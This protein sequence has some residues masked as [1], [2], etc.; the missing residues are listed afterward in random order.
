MERID[1]L[2]V[3]SDEARVSGARLGERLLIGVDD[4]PVATGWELKPE[5]LCRGD[6]CVP[7]HDP[8]G[9]VDGDLVDLAQVAARIGAV[10]AVDA[11]EGIAVF[12]GPATAVADVTAGSRQAPELALPTLDGGE[13]RLSDFAGQKRMVVAWS[14]WCGCRHELGAWQALQ[15]ELGEQNIRILSVALDEDVDAVRP[16]VDEA[17]ATFPVMV[18]REGMLAERYGVVNVP[19]T[20]WIDEDDQIVRPPDIAPGDDRWKDFTQ[21][22]AEAHHDA[23]RRWVND[24]EAPMTDDQV[25]AA[26]TWTGAVRAVV[27]PRPSWPAEL[28]PQH[29]TPPFTMAHVCEPPAARAVATPAMPL[30][31][32]QCDESVVELLPSWPSLFLPQHATPPPT[33]TAQ[34]WL[35][36]AARAMWASPRPLTATGVSRCVVE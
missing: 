15:E 18:D 36:P 23:L 33:V 10:I 28:S 21:K 8:A 30:T 34:V 13:V 16:W 4:L 2:V 35:K 29:F 6:V 1:V 26:P 31:C 3:T 14:S 25:V 12:G 24:G 27:S 32:T 20:I 22:D 19:T 11:G 9:L 7:V 5:G 17:G